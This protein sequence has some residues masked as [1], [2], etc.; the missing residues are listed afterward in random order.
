MVETNKAAAPSMTLTM[1]SDR[2][3]VVTRVF[4]APRRL[5][6]EAWTTPERL[7]QWWGPRS[8]TLT[9]CEIDLRAGGAWRFVVRAPNGE[10]Y[11]FKG[12]YREIVPY[13]RLVYTDSFDG[14]PD[15]EALV[16]LTFDEH[17][18]RTTLTMASLYE[19]VEYRDGHLASGMEQGMTETLDRLAEHLAR[20]KDHMDRELT[21]TRIF[22]APR[23]LVFKAWIDPSHVAQWWGPQGFTNP[24]CE[25]DVRP[26]GAIRIDMTG[27]DGVVIP[28]TG[29]FHE[30]VEPERLVFTT[31][32]F[33]DETG[34]AQLEGVNTVTF[35][36]YFGKTK[37]T[38]HVAVVKATLAVRGSLDSMAQGWNESLD[39]LAED[40]VQTRQIN[41]GQGGS[42]NTVRSAD[43]TPIAFEK[44][45]QGP[46][47]ILV[48]GALCYRAFGPMRPL[49]ALLASHFT[50][51][52]YDRRGRGE[53]GDTL[54]YAVE[55]EVE[56]IDA[57]IKEA[58]GSAFVYGISSGAALAMEAAIKL[59]DKVKKLAMYE[60]PYNSDES[61]R[62]AWK[63]YRKQ[64]SELTAAGRGGDA[65][66]LF[67]MYV[68]MP[69]DHVPQ[70]RQNP[71][72]PLW[73]SVGLTLTYD[74]AA[75]G[76]DA[77][78]PTGRA[79]R[80]AAPAL[81]MDGGASFPF[82]HIT[83]AAL[84]KAMP[85]AQHRTLEGQT[86]ELAAEA[87]APVLTEFFGK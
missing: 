58:G 68:G 53:S 1:P 27:P 63:T 33:V 6:F 44:T 5:V 86:H 2:E 60:A 54:P 21:I 75:L 78:A 62:Q 76:E 38:L 3:I 52:A 13:E 74:A 55:R 42:M 79:A 43:G 25:L 35:E 40:L 14:V 84:A 70:M 7:A 83:A 29:V 56:D 50:V 31:R 65:V 37:L 72:W 57:L 34:N 28:T 16:K 77:S 32:S 39:R 9:V 30:I 41:E 36:D 73:E 20:G 67:M 12:V 61:A 46:A 10:E 4:N 23:E 45:G 11:G 18:G 22:D 19:S 17:D 64:L 81:V 26:G 15:H 71:M 80:V 48:D 69:A 66:A 51:Y 85:H 49:A 82:M 87:V 8:L 24:V 47:L 59:G